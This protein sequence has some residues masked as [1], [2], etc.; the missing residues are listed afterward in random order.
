MD[1]HTLK[2]LEFD[3]IRTSVAGYCLSDEGREVLESELPLSNPHEV[4]ALKKS[5]SHI[6]AGLR[7]TGSP[8]I[9]FPPVQRAAALIGKPGASL[10]LE[11]LYS[12]GLWAKSFRDFVNWLRSSLFQIPVLARV[13]ESLGPIIPLLESAPEIGKISQI[14]FKVLTN[15]GELRELP[16]IREARE[17]IARTH[18]ELDSLA[19]SYFRD[20]EI[21]Q[22]LQSGEPTLRDGRTVLALRSNFKGRIKGIVHEVSQTGQTVFIEPSDL[23]EK[24]NALVEEEARLNAEIRRVLRETTEELRDHSDA[25]EKA[26]EVLSGL[27]GLYAR[28]V[29][30][31][32]TGAVLASERDSGFVLRRA[33]HPFLGNKA[34]PIDVELPEEVK[35]LVVTGPN[36]GGKTVTL[37][38]IGLL[39][40]M[41]QFGL[42]VPAAPE[43]AFAVFDSV[44][45]DI[46]DEQSI[47]QSLST[48]SGH[49]RVMGG[50]VTSVTGRSLVLLDELGSGTDPEEGCA[51]AMGL[52]DFFISKES[53]TI[54]TTHHGI[55]KN[56]GYSREHCLNASMDFDRTSL[57]PTYRILMGVPGESRALEIAVKNGLPQ[58]I[59]ETAAG[60]LSDERTDVALLIRSLNEKHRKLEDMEGDRRKRLRDAMDRQRKADLQALRNR[61]KELELRSAG[62]G[63]LKRLL[64]ESR[65]TLENLVRELREGELTQVKTRAVKEFLLNLASSADA[66][67]VILSEER[68]RLSEE[69][70]RMDAVASRQDSSFCIDSS[71]SETIYAPGAP[72]TASPSEILA[73]R[74][75]TEKN[76]PFSS[77]DSVRFGPTRIS[78]VLVRLAKPGY[79]LVE[80]G[81]LKLTVAEKEMTRV[82]GTCGLPGETK[83]KA[84]ASYQVELA[85]RED[86][87]S[88][89][90]VFE[91][92][93]RGMRL[94]EALEAVERQIDAATL[95]NLML[96]SIIHG[97]GEGVLGE[98][99]HQQLRKHPAVAEYH[100]ARPEE[101]GHGKTI[102]R[103]K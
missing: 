34:V 19:S 32:N 72:N 62:V 10:E 59:V 97:T 78:G 51:I 29:H 31:K 5:V 60:Y 67:A 11:E 66:E 57:A 98:G 47:D 93:L 40:L 83:N 58:S 103:L 4:S 63:E 33:K 38:T 96:F 35:T 41:N 102:V 52:L 85:E 14:V 68:S 89:K 86:G 79:W 92:N 22:M 54:A 16:G 56:Y 61:Q 91:L 25:L 17:R 73:N 13:V 36:T 77:G 23:V 88:R 71:G 12:A 46:G 70:Q 81:S 65:K 30:A 9:T 84:V 2:L 44:Y 100:F 28:A 101:G 82:G 48:F 39:A 90:A 15:D 18:R 20:P 95:Q 21:R 99:I 55:L 45:A 74:I 94:V 53:L 43:T 7:E 49:M 50:I 3:R 27:D 37:K 42:G 26:R 24:N 64:S 6:L 8:S 1:E 87:V 76:K 80:S 75:E 69:M